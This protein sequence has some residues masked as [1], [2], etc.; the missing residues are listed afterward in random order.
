MNDTLL[1]DND[2]A[3]AAARIGC[4]VAAVKAVA[5]VES[6]RGPFNPDGS[7]TTLFEGHV[8]SRLTQHR[9]DLTHPDL[10]Y[11]KWSRQWYGKTWRAEQD[12]LFRASRLAYKPALMSAS[13]G[14]FQ[15]MGFNYGAA[16]HV[17]VY[18]F[19]DAMRESAAKQLDAFVGFIETS[20]LS[21]E[22]RDHRWAD[23]ARHYN[24]PGY[25]VN[26]Y[27]QRIAEAYSQNAK[28]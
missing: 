7:P 28:A 15:I 27:D 25:A 14:M 6:P 21:D 17:S 18:T 19:V 26:R 8:F 5:Q 23:F 4:D 3:R 11:P 9:Y 13:W 12:R 20:G 24:G 22:L 2:Y 1:T 10:S 16:G